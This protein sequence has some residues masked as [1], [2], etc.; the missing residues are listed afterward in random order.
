MAEQK[1][2]IIE[3]GQ[4]K[5]INLKNKYSVVNGKKVIKLQGINPDN[6]VDVTKVFVEGYKNDGKFGVSYSCKAN[7]NG[8]EVS[9]WLNEKEHNI[10]KDCGGI[11]DVVRLSVK[12][13]TF[14]NSKTGM[15][16]IYDKLFFEKVE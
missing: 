4:Y 1:L 11:G 9:F 13:E 6:H 16:S 7:Y 10:Y 15:E 5:S 14:V 3:K 12:K 8:Q 2:D